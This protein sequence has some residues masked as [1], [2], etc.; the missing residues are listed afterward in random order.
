M[1]TNPRNAIPEI[2]AACCLVV[3]LAWCGAAEAKIGFLVEDVRRKPDPAL[4]AEV[5]ARIQKELYRQGGRPPSPEELRARLPEKAHGSALTT[6]EAAAAGRVL[7]LDVV[8][9][10]RIREKNWSHDPGAEL[11]F[12]LASSGEEKLYRS[13]EPTPNLPGE[14]QRVV[15][16]NY[17]TII[18]WDREL[19]EVNNAIDHDCR[20]P[21]ASFLKDHPEGGTRFASY[22]Y[23]QS[24]KQTKVGFGA[25]VP[26]GAVT[27][28]ATAILTYLL[29]NPTWEDPPCEDCLINTTTGV[30]LAAFF[31]G[32]GSIGAL[33]TGMIVGTIHLKRVRRLRPLL[34]ASPPAGESLALRL[35]PYAAPGGGGLALDLRF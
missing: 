27:G 25:L 17:R 30:L 15:A 28:A 13:I 12:L 21:Y 11:R 29:V 2:A 26:I 9:V 32:L 34:D 6:A 1:A 31:C 19:V 23:D 3:A 8:I 5:E 7:G 10:V 22:M 4:V 14:A 35:A 16:R 20:S 18:T 24:V 33:S